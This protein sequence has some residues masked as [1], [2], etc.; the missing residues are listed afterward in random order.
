MLVLAQTKIQHPV[1]LWVLGCGS[2]FGFW[3]TQS[4][5]LG[6]WHRPDFHPGVKARTGG[7]CG[8]SRLPALG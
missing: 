8:C 3:R 2:R 4:K 1:S 6:H 5:Q 7:M